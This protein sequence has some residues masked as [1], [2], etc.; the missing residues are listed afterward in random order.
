MKRIFGIFGRTLLRPYS[1]PV[2]RISSDINKIKSHFKEAH[3]AAKE[4]GGQHEYIDDTEQGREQIHSSK[5]AFEILY[6]KNGWDEA[7]L[8][9]QKKGVRRAKWV[10]WVGMFLSII[11]AIIVFIMATSIWVYV[12]TFFGALL[13][14]IN[15]GSRGLK[16][17]VFEAQLHKRDLISFK[18]F[19][20]SSDKWSW[21][22]R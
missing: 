10:G 21:I 9:V 22:S 1:E 13:S 17:S 7:Q 20:A 19:W 16:Y 15:F 14:T 3:D 5:D 2:K 8:E 6:Q 18:E 4:K 11:I 12:F